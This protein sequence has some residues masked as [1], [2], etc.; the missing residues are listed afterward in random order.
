MQALPQE[1]RQKVS[2]KSI[3]NNRTNIVYLYTNCTS[4]N[5]EPPLVKIVIF[6]L[7]AGKGKEEHENHL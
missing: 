5:H 3:E 4:I 7:Q 6:I 2:E 1:R